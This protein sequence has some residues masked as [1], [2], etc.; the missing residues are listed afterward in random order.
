MRRKF[1]FIQ[2]LKGVAGYVFHEDRLIGERTQLD[3]VYR[4]RRRLFAGEVNTV[5]EVLNV[6]VAL[7]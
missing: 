3:H 7:I 4:M 5:I 6:G 1:I 2:I